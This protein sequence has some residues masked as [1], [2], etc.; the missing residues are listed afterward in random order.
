MPPALVLP[1]PGAEPPALL[2]ALATRP[3]APAPKL[4]PPAIGAA[5]PPGFTLPAVPKPEAPAV[6]LMLPLEPLGPTGPSAPPEELQALMLTPTAAS[7]MVE[8]KAMVRSDCDM[9]KDPLQSG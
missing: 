9:A 5:P 7:T 8:Q 6:E 1:P 4:E 2:P 3:P